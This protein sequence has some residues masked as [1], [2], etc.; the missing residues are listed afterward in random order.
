[1]YKIYDL[2]GVEYLIR[3]NY[4]YNIVMRKYYLVYQKALHSAA[5]RHALLSE[6]G[7]VSLLNEVQIVSKSHSALFLLIN[8]NQQCLF[9]ESKLN[10]ITWIFFLLMK[11]IWFIMMIFFFLIPI[12]YHYHLHSMYSQKPILT[13]IFLELT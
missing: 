7:S 10:K 13:C 6:K 4:A 5:S 8:Q 3:R 9:H 12:P 1:M 11:L 2:F